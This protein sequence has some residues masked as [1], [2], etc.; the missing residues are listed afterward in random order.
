MIEQL[1]LK[2]AEVAVIKSNIPEEGTAEGINLLGGIS[3]FILEDDQ[4]FIKINFRL[5]NGF[6]VNTNINVIKKVIDLCKEAGTEKIYIGSFPY[7]ETDSKSIAIMIG[8]PDV[9]ESMGAQLV[10][11]D[12][13]ISFPQ[14]IV[15]I[16]NKEFEVP[17]I[18][19]E[20][21]KLISINQISVDPL[22]KITQSLVNLYSIVSDKYQ[23][24]QKI[25][26]KGKDYLFLDQ[27]KQ[28][29][30][31]NIIDVFSIKKPNLSIN[32][33]FYTLEGAGPYIYKDSN[34]LKTNL[35]VLGNDAIAVDFITLKLM[36][37][38]PMKNELIVEAR[39]KNLG[40]TDLQKIS[41]FGESL[42]KINLDINFCVS[43]LEDINVQNTSIK[44]GQFCSGCF[45]QAYH[46]LNLMKTIMTKDL[47][48]IK[49]Q[50]FLIGENPQEPDYLENI[51][52]FGNCAIS[53]TKDRSFRKVLI[54][55][56]KNVIDDT[57]KK[58]KRDK[59]PI[60][61][62]QIKE[63][64]NKKIIELPGCPPDIFECISSLITYY[65]KKEVP[66]LSLY[67]E[68]VS[69]FKKKEKSM[70]SDKEGL[71]NL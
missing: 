5:P 6:P 13:H 56:R 49:K 53:S 25:L 36:K 52:L 62:P 43:K 60:N 59:K 63:K 58:F 39:E 69:S 10:Y 20:S 29:L 45:K 48:Y 14:K 21:D 38:D 7:K 16:R 22:F 11:L 4:V 50:S 27:Y 31:S 9:I 34:L 17:K 66:N 26:R 40:I 28:D 68:F 37:M 1:N 19:L 71:S 35:V 47:K 23:K 46:I 42:D 64:S 30:V 33:L 8:Y 3:K 70:K 2:N 15:K 65:N 24:I 55:K 51:L 54:E 32:D 12:N 67:N 18:I 61:K 57:K 44:K 41:I